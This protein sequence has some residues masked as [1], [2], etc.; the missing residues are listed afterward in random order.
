MK[1]NSTIDW[2]Q[3]FNL[4]SFVLMILGVLSATIAF[5]GF[6][7]PNHFIDGGI[8]GISVFISEVFHINIAIPI[9]VLNLPF[10]ILCYKKIGKTLAIQSLI[11]VLLLALAVQFIE[12][13]TITKD[14]VLI[15]I[16]GGIFIGMGIGLVIRSGGVIDGLEIM[17]IL[18]KKKSA[19]SANEIMLAAAIV[20]FVA[21]GIHFGWDTVMYS[22]VTYFTAIK[23]ADYVVDG[24]E[25]YNSLTIVSGQSEEVKQMLVQKYNK[26]ISVYK[27]ERGYLPNNFEIHHDCDILITI[28]TRLELR[29]L[30]NAIFAIDPNAF[31]YIQS[32]KEVQGGIVKEKM[33]H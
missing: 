22:I 2:A 17:A 19:F 5:K 27:G 30:K 12:I 33:K 23:T 9:I 4:R 18:T 20:L 15:A 28:I 29:Q 24:I 16:F 11:A 8:N 10:I 31:I 14:Y 25:E 21:L 7:I 32:I 26:A 1:G 13:P 3:I 6:M